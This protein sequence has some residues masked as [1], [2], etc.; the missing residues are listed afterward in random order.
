MLEPEILV[1]AVHWGV[2]YVLLENSILTQSLADFL[3]ENG[4]DLIVGGHPV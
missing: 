4:A 1:V 2:E 3:V